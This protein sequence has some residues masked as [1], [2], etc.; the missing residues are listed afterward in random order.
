[1]DD[2]V[3][4]NFNCKKILLLGFGLE[5]RASLR[6][7]KSKFVDTTV[8]IADSSNDFCLESELEPFIFRVYRGENWLNTV[9][10]YDVILRSPGVPISVIENIFKDKTSRPI[11]TSATEIFLERNH[12]TTIGVTGTKGKSTTS[13]LL[14]DV[15]TAFGYKVLLVGNIGTPAISS[16]CEK[17]DYFIYELSSYQLQDVR[18]SPHISFFL[19]FYPEHLD[20]HGTIDK[21]FEAKSRIFQFQQK[22]DLL[23]LDSKL[24]QHIPKIPE[25]VLRNIDSENSNLLVQGTSIFGEEG[26]LIFDMGKSSL[27]GRGNLQNI[28]A[29]FEFASYLGLDLDLVSQTIYDFKPLPHRLEIVGTRKGVQFVNDSISTVP[30]ATINAIDA[31]NF[32]IKTLVL[33]GFDR[34][35]DFQ[36]LAETVLNS[37]IPLVLLFK[38]SGQRI[39]DSIKRF[40]VES[41]SALPEMTFVESMTE[42][43]EIV[44]AKNFKHGIC[45]LSPASPS[46]G[47]FKNFEERGRFFREAVLRLAP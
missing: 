9:S 45:L 4:V 3:E 5:G 12:S 39:F 46:F 24:F 34:G 25:S 42:V 28:L 8:S 47:K 43:V 29:V 14:R 7:L 31:F 41:C 1:M 27:R 16:I 20:H 35:V 38:P 17:V 15:L 23:F 30:Q 40:A 32:Q 6:Y 19:N 2:N 44:S 33:G 13:S 36:E 26:R 37:K 10:E 21:Y 11:V 22:R 18:F